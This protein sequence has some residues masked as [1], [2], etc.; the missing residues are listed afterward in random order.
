MHD[1]ATIHH[2]NRKY[3]I[4]FNRGG[5]GRPWSV[6]RELGTEKARLCAFQTKADAQT[7]IDFIK[8]K[9]HA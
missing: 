1:L 6:Y 5:Q 9:A 8:D 3:T 2:I 7:F 4:D